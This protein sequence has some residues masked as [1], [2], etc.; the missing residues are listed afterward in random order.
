MYYHQIVRQSF[1]DVTAGVLQGDT[2]APYLFII[3]L[4]YV[5]RTALTNYEDMGFTLDERRSS[6]NP[7]IHLTDADFADD[8]ALLSDTI[9]KAQ[10]L[11]LRVENAAQIVG[12]QR[13][14]T[15]TEFMLYHQPPGDIISLNGGK[16]KKVEDFKYLGSWIRNS[17]KDVGIRIAKAWSAMNKMDM[18]WKSELRRDLKIQY[19]RATVEC[20]LLYGSE[21][22]T[23]TK[24][25]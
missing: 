8:L 2:L 1:F 23:L 9:E 17:E 4:D 11:L 10:L 20:A 22:W 13:N 24:K 19:F 6:R 14:V 21:S 15:K 18:I 25:T 5:M 7:A 12:L 16:L 3:T